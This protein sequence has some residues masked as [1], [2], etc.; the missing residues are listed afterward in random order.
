[1]LHHDLGRLKHEQCRLINGSRWRSD[2]DALAST[3]SGLAEHKL[4]TFHFPYDPTNK[5]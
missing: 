5:K 3:L 4:K 1:L 2:L